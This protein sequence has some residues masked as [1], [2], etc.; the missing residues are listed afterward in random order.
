MV[1]DQQGLIWCLF[2]GREVWCTA[3]VSSVSPSSEQPYSIYVSTQHRVHFLPGLE[4]EKPDPPGS[5]PRL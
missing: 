4:H 5:L 3:D 1:F 2:L